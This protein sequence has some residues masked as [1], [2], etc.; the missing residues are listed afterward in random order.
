MTDFFL[1]KKY[2]VLNEIACGGMGTVYLATDTKLGR[3]V[4]IKMLHPQYSGETAFAQRFLREAKAM[5]KLDHPNIIRIWSVEEENNN[6]SIV[7]EYFPGIDLKNILRRKGPLPLSECLSI[8]IQIIQGLAYAHYMGIIHRDIKPGN[9]L[10]NEQGIVKITDFGIAAAFNESSLTVEGTVMGTPEYMAPEQARAEQI[11]PK[12]DIYSVGM[13]LYEMITGKTPYK[14]MPGQSIVGKLAFDSEN[15]TFQFPVTV[16]KEL[17][18]LICQMTQKRTESRI[19]DTNEILNTLKNLIPLTES[20]SSKS[21][22][23]IITTQDERTEALT[24][25]VEKEKSSSLSSLPQTLESSSESRTQPENSFKKISGKAPDSH[26]PL[27]PPPSPP[28]LPPPVTKKMIISAFGIIGIMALTI[29]VLY[30]YQGPKPDNPSPPPTEEIPKETPS[31]EKDAIP[32]VFSEEVKTTMGKFSD[33]T[34]EVRQTQEEIKEAFKAF[35]AKIENQK[36]KLSNPSIP[37]IESER[38]KWFK[39]TETEFETLKEENQAL[40]NAQE[41]IIQST[42][43]TLKGLLQ[44]EARALKL[45]IPQ[46]QRS[47]LDQAK[48]NL[49]SA[50]QELHSFFKK[51]IQESQN[52]LTQLGTDLEKARKKIQSI[53]IASTP[54][55]PTFPTPPTIQSTKKVKEWSKTIQALENN[56]STLNKEIQSIVN[57]FDRSTKEFQ[58]RLSDL[59]NEIKRIGGNPT[60]QKSQTQLTS[61]QD[62]LH[63]I[64]KH[65]EKLF[66][67][68]QPKKEQWKQ[69]LQEYRDTVNALSDESL[70]KEQNAEMSKV[71]AK[72]TEIQNL[73]EAFPP[74][75]WEQL[76]TLSVKVQASLTKTNE[77]VS[78]FFGKTE[79]IDQQLQTLAGTVEEGSQTL[80]RLSSQTRQSQEKLA[81][82]FE[83]LGERV[84]TFSKAPEAQTAPTTL[85]ALQQEL[86]TLQQDLDRTLAEHH[87]QARQGA[88][89]LPQTL[90]IL[91][92]LGDQPLT[93]LQQ[94]QVQALRKQTLGQQQRLQELQKVDWPNVRSQ[95]TNLDT[96]LTQIVANLRKDEDRTPRKAKELEDLNTLLENFIQAYENRDLLRLKLTTNMSESRV[97]NLDIMFNK[98]PLIKAHTKII[99]T[100]A[101]EA[102]VKLFIDQLVDKEGKTI[103]PNFIIRETSLTIP[104]N[105]D[106]WGKIQW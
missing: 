87:Q 8:T 83:D 91:A 11:G 19:Q 49:E 79:A 62:Q 43:N 48:Q 65:S 71:H 24:S 103:T 45:N 88:S 46:N 12:T 37:E 38:Q 61:L 13:V 29:F 100:S 7:M 93:P 33:L 67:F 22:E 40:K 25:H 75:S 47:E 106:S 82:R 3:N 52:M 41:K 60:D 28:T 36:K 6:H 39:K 80:Q 27:S 9:I 78:E 58:T 94:Q 84:E 69:T 23:T 57:D 10:V 66:A 26:S 42:D 89:A 72:L 70:D 16:P 31:S 86:K 85:T 56:A 81:N 63:T 95:Y 96:A 101:P 105:K 44:K 102:F 99:S 73:V 50:H 90:Q 32:P 34:K 77:V 98:Y 76:Q 15:P 104:K 51:Q 53:S 2:R 21:E 17:Q 74:P 54:Q 92:A 14:G 5:A 18:T 68:H 64:Q 30:L 20:L 35:T 4:A 55:A 1:F 97:R 59:E